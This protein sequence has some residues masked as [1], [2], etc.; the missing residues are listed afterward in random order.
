MGNNMGEGV[1]IKNPQ[2]VESLGMTIEVI[3]KPYTHDYLNNSC[4]IS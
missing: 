1:I 2:A 4:A 3:L